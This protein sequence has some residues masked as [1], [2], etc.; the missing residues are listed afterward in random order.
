MD[1]AL[2]NEREIG[3]V[4]AVSTYKVSVLLTPDLRSQVRA[5]PQRITT[6]TQIGSYLLFSVAPGEYAIGIVVGASEDEAIEP[7]VEK[8][9]TLQLTRARRVLRVNLLGH[10]SEGPRFSPGVSVYPSLETAALL[11]EED[12]LKV[13]L[14]YNPLDDTDTAVGLG[15]SP[16][17]SRQPV[18]ASFNDLLSR[19]LGIIGN[20]GSGKSYSVAS[21]VQSAL[22]IKD[23]AVKNARIIILD[24]NGEYS[25]AFIGKEV[26]KDLNKVYVNGQSFGLPLWTFNLSELIAFFNASS[27]SQA[28]VLERVITSLR[29]ETVDPDTAKKARKQVKLIDKCLNISGSLA[30]YAA[31]SDGNAVS[32]NASVSITDLIYFFQELLSLLE[33]GNDYVSKISKILETAKSNDNLQLYTPNYWKDLRTKKDFA[34]FKSLAPKTS[35]IVREFADEVDLLLQQMKIDVITKCNLKMVT[36]DSPV[37][38]EPKHLERDALF[39]IAVSSFRG[40]E[41]IQEY[42]ATLRLRIHER[43]SDKRWSVFTQAADKEFKD[44]IENVLGNESSNVTVVDCSM[45]AYDVLPF[46]CAIFGRLLLELRAHIEAKDRTTQPYVLVLEEAHNYL[47]PYRESEATGTLLS[48]EAFERIAKEGR[49][50]GLSLI[51]ASQRP[52]DV[53]PTVISQCANFLVHRIQNPEDID[54]FKKILPTGSREVLDQMPILAPGDGLL[55]GSSVNVPSRV[56]IKKPQRPPESQTPKPW[57]AWQVDSPTFDYKKAVDL[58]IQESE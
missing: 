37:Y 36:A 10:L 33:E 26:S 55:L 13:I 29:E 6:I 51:I 43:L 3:K 7:D 47:R 32:D 18:T 28:P 49:K 16:I 45:L 24:I 20:T 4:V 46:F 35:G 15:I 1:G 9:M 57:K 5:Y 17:Y 42:I 50:F 30:A 8:G 41:R 44:V 53:S 38:F 25:K 56:R 34:G 40:Q 54:Y 23:K 11:P 48:R 39:R 52:S 14:E 2:S 58:W 21:I 31:E 12:Q 22:E 19:P 27:A